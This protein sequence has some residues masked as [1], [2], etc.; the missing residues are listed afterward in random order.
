MPGDKQGEQTIQQMLA[1]KNKNT[2]SEKSDKDKSK[3]SAGKTS[4][5]EPPNMRLASEL[6]F[7]E[8]V[9]LLSI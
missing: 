7:N 5:K 4:D 6:S 1:A 3:P 9:D 2:Q 8:S